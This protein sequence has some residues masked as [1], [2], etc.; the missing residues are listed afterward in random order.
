M[1]PVTFLRFFLG[2]SFMI[3]RDDPGRPAPVPDLQMIADMLEERFPDSDLVCRGDAPGFRSFQ[4]YTGQ[5]QLQDDVLYILGDAPEG[6]PVDSHPYLAVGKIDGGAPH[7]CGLDTRQSELINLV[8]GIFQRYGDLVSE[9]D[10]I[11][12]GGSLEDLCRA[13]CEFLGNPMFIHDSEFNILALPVQEAGM[14]QMDYNPRSG[15]YYIP[16]W[17]VDEYKLSDEY[18]ATLQLREAGIWGADQYPY[19][20]RTL[21]VNLWDGDRYCGR[22]LINELRSGLTKGQF[23]LAEL[24]ADYAVQIIRRDEQNADRHHRDFE[25]TFRSLIN[26]S[27]VDD[28]DLQRLLSVMGWQKHDRYVLTV[29]QSQDE[30]LATASERTVQNQLFRTFPEMF[31]LFHEQR[32]CVVINL[33]RMNMPFPVV[34]SLFAPILRDSLL[35]GGA[36]FPV[37][38]ILDLPDAYRQAVFALNQSFRQRQSKWLLTFED[39]AVPYMLNSANLQFSPD[40]IASPAL[41]FLR[42]YDKDKGTDYYNTL[43]CFLQCERSIPRASSALIIHRT[44]LEYRL[45]KIQNLIHLDLEDTDLRLYLLISFRIIDGM[46]QEEYL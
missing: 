35:Y 18:L 40:M 5:Q 44:T 4:I 42:N 30:R 10:R 25:D 45:E 21:Y 8:L 28:M 22:L 39:C 3:H 24:I 38:D 34:R 27:E 11:A 26:R 13:G 2:E 43:R 23:K 20:L 32:L 19:H 36:S 17:L 33:T 1:G 16:L 29:L 15:R 12:G 14:I 41:Q 46:L 37:D 31:G 6:F 7:I 9:L